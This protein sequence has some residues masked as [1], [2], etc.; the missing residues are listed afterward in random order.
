MKEIFSAFGSEVFRPLVTIVIPGAISIC[1]W[2]VVLMQRFVSMRELASRNHAET[3]VLLA[4]AAL[5]AGLIVEDIGSRIESS[6]YDSLLC[7]KAGFVSHRDEWNKY[8]RVAFK[9]E[10]IGQH[11]LRTIL[12]RFKFEL[13]T[14]IG[15]L[16]SAPAFFLTNL[17]P[18]TAA[19]SCV[20]CVVAASY[21]LAVEARD[22]HQ[23]LSEV[24]REI[25]KGVLIFGAEDQAAND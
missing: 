18:R 1:C 6:V 9:L 19:V 4:I 7:K 15:L 13:G 14:S 3:A 2:F 17:S 11:Y 12:L 10:P 23:V 24:R 8:L 20:A 21:A 25:L 22:S 5:A 16:L